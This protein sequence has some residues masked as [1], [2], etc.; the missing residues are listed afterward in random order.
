MC[1]VSAV[2]RDGDRDCASTSR[3]RR[4]APRAHCHAWHDQVGDGDALERA[5][6][7]VLG[8]MNHV[9]D[10]ANGVIGRDALF[11]D[12][13]GDQAV[14]T[15]ETGDDVAA[16]DAAGVPPELHATLA[17]RMGDDEAHAH[18]LLHDLEQVVARYAIVGGDFRHGCPTVRPGEVDQD[19]KSVV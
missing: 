3:D 18:E 12:H 14:A 5:V 6:H 9:A 17:A 8:P 4:G 7:R 16:A 13:P 15:L 11:A 10:S 19:R 2:R 1:Y